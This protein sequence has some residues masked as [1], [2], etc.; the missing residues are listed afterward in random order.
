MKLQKI[1]QFVSGTKMGSEKYQSICL[2]I[3]KGYIATVVPAITLQDDPMI[4][5]PLVIENAFNSIDGQNFVHALML[6]TLL[7]ICTVQKILYMPSHVF[8]TGDTS[9]LN[10]ICPEVP[11]DCF[12]TRLMAHYTISSL[13]QECSKVMSW[14]VKCP[15]S[16]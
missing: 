7:I 10:P 9:F 5:I 6:K 8:K 2:P 11:D 14:P 3:F 12:V 16:C 1:I 13:R 4:V 15:M